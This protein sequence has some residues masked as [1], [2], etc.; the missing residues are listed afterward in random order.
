MMTLQYID[1]QWLDHVCLSVAGMHARRIAQVYG[2]VLDCE[3]KKGKYGMTPSVY[4]E[5]RYYIDKYEDACFKEALQ[6]K[7]NVLDAYL[8]LKGVYL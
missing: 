5:Y 2:L 6:N 4:K 8:T 7:L 3:S 1:R